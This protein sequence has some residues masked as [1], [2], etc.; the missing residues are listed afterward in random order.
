MKK[1]ARILTVIFFLVFLSG[2]LACLFFIRHWTGTDNVSFSSRPEFVI[3][4]ELA[5]TPDQWQRGLM[6]RKSLPEN[7]GML[8]VFPDE[9]IQSFWMKNTLIPL[10]MIFIS[11][12]DR[13]VDIKNNFLPCTTDPCPTYQSVLPAKYVLEVNAGMVQKEGIAIG[14]QAMIKK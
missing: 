3:R 4:A 13:V 12:N 8:F 11:A 1:I 2:F 9:A 10:D 7:S 6:F 5:L 14:D